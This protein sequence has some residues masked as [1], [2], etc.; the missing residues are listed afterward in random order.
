MLLVQQTCTVLFSFTFFTEKALKCLCGNGPY[1]LSFGE[2]HIYA[3]LVVS[4]IE[5]GFLLY[6]AEYFHCLSIT[7]D[8]ELEF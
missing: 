5:M 7:Q 3:I 2:E 4:R 1:M 6:Y 8:L